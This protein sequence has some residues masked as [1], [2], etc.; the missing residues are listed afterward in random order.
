[1]VVAMV[2]ITLLAMAVIDVGFDSV[3]IFCVTLLDGHFDRIYKIP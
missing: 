1:M 2:T 3:N